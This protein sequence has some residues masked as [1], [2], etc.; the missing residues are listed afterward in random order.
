MS[1]RRPTKSEIAEFSMEYLRHK[2][3][4]KA[5]KKA[6]PSIAD[7]KST[8]ALRSIAQKFYK[9]PDVQE[10]I[11]QLRDI[12]NKK[13]EDDAD[14]CVESIKTRLLNIYKQGIE[15]KIDSQGN[16]IPVSLQSA[17]SALSEI[18][19]MAGNYSAEKTETDI[20]IEITKKII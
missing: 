12:F 6:F 16:M 14:Y 5:I 1:I 18:N 17:I 11:E 20:K 19:K 4:L 15:K 9:K 7:E 8:D 10:S 2:S 13:L 3:Q